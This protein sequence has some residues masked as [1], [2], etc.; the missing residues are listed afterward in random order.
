MGSQ[1]LTRSSV[2]GQSGLSYEVQ[3]EFLTLVRDS[4]NNPQ[5]IPNS[6]SRYQDVVSKSRTRLNYVIAP[7]LF[8]MSENFKNKILKKKKK[9]DVDEKSG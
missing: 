8:L 4:V 5:W 6:I 7:G 3:E 1:V 2:I 9:K